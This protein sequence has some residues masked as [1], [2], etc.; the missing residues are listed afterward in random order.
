MFFSGSY[1]NP[2]SDFLAHRLAVLN[3]GC[4]F[5]SSL[6]SARL[7]IEESYTKAL[8]SLTADVPQE[9]SEYR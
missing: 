1:K 3:G 7:G 5:L 9:L 6:L 4:G 2:F 8:D